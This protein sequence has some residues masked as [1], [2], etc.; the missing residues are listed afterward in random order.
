MAAAPVSKLF[1]Q[2][3]EPMPVETITP[4]D[5]CVSLAFAAADEISGRAVR[6]RADE[7]VV[8][9][10]QGLAVVQRRLGHGH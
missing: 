2:P 1:S 10:I 8:H 6:F 5:D 3:V 4:L 9:G 7:Q